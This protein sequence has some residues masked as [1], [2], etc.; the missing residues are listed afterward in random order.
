MKFERPFKVDPSSTSAFSA[1]ESSLLL[2]EDPG[3]GFASGMRAV[4]I[5]GGTGAPMSI[6]TLLS[7]G[8]QTSAVVAMADDG[9]STGALREEA[10]VTA[11]GDIRKCLVAFARNQQDPFVRAFKYRI[12]VARDHTLG[13]L[14]LAALE[15]ACESFPEAIGICERMLDAQG[16]VYPSTLDHVTLRARTRD[17]RILDGQAVACKSKTA[18]EKVQLVSEENL[19]RPY[20]P[21][22]DAIREADLIVLGPGSLFTSII[23]NLLVPGVVDAIRQSRGRVL[24]VCSLADVQGETWGLTVREHVEALV[25]HGLEGLI[26]FVLV[27]AEDP[28]RADRSPSER[29]IRGLD[30]P[31]E[32]A[33]PAN[34][35]GLMRAAKT[36]LVMMSYDDMA[37]IQ[38]LGPVVIV[39][40]LADPDRPTWH[41]PRALRE[42][43]LG[44]LKLCRSRQR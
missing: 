32:F 30:T 7:L 44:V 12:A 29:L 15:D 13:N 25:S 42:A 14:M 11:P 21:A 17:G 4:V 38:A 43:F 23:P 6:R 19:I 27:H 36:R 35:E 33:L 37:A 22:L 24:F 26:D 10:N 1:L 40:N 8:L 16:H 31:D 20:E 41:A 28:V 3:L 34:E 5:G 18:L 9:G 2:D 39:R